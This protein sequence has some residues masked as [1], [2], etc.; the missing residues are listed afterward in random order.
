MGTTCGSLSRAAVCASRR[1]REAKSALVASAAGSSLSATTRSFLRVST[2]RHTSPMPPRP[3]RST[4]RYGP[5]DVVTT[6]FIGPPRAPPGGKHAKYRS[7][8]CSGRACS[9]DR[10]IAPRSGWV[11]DRPAGAGTG[12]AGSAGRLR[13][14]ATAAAP[15]SGTNPVRERRPPTYGERMAGGYDAEHIAAFFD[16]YGDREWERHDSPAERVALAVHAD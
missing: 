11:S 4:N 3:I 13:W 8:T 2:A 9:T 10:V 1:N 5:N 12:R 14:H 7:P 15:S 16:D 6:E